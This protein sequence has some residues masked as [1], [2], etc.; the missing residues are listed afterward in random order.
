[1]DDRTRNE[2][3]MFYL[4]PVIEPGGGDNDDEVIVL[5]SECT[6][7]II[8]WSVASSNECGMYSEMLELSV[9]VCVSLTKTNSTLRVMTSQSA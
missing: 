5:C 3:I 6:M 2:Y 4:P 8:R 1:M 7:A 9:D